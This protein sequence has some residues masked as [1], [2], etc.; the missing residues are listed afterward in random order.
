MKEILCNAFCAALQCRSVPGGYAVELP[1]QN[2]DGDPLLLYYIRLS[3]TEWRIED[4]G[5]QVALLE[6]NGVDL[7]GRSRG[8]ALNS[9]LSEYD[10]TFDQDAR[11]LSSPALKEG[12]L[13][14]AS[15]SFVALLLRLQ[16]LALLSPQI[17]RNTFRD[18]AVSAIRGKFEG[19]AQIEENAPISS[20]LPAFT[21]DVRITSPESLPL[22]VYLA[23][24]EE[25]ALQALVLKMA[26]EKYR[27]E[28]IRVV[29]LLEKARDNP[30]R[31]ATYALSQARL[32]DVLSFRGVESE[33]M[34]KLVRDFRSSQQLH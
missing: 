4:D 5:T 24:S 18:D 11:T 12:D 33:A 21:A 31:D 17:V 8:G 6:A 13:G 22:A 29:L 26:L 20:K 7:G 16:D 19:I 27:S 9:L 1:Y 32:D 34:D 28:P 30:V 2:A 3:P 15:L 10:V 25:R 14:E 23:T